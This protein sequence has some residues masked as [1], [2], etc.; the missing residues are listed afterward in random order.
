MPALAVNATVTT[1]KDIR[2][3]PQLRTKLL[4]ELRA[5]QA[6][7]E[8]LKALEHAKAKHKTAIGKLRDE[9]GEQ[10]IKLDGFTV[11]LVAGV[12]TKLDKK[13]LIQQGVTMAM[14][15]NA[16][17]VTPKRAYDRISLPGEAEG[18]E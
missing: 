10:S 15:E 3:A 14:I 11:T 8:Q 1:T 12:S 16:T 18:E 5:Y 13:L 17:V 2:L 6:I 4:K 9:T 7:E